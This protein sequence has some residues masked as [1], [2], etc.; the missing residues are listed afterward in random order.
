MLFHRV[1]GAITPLSISHVL[2]FRS[3][4]YPTKIMSTSIASRRRKP[5]RPTRTAVSAKRS[6]LPAYKNLALS[7]EK[8]VKDLL[9]RMTLEEKAA[10][11]MCVW[12][13]KPETLVDANG[14]FDLQK[15]KAAFR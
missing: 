7:A 4:H 8:R 1:Y 6:R 5:T 13:Q 15:A 12:Q 2:R 10:Q 3:I 9:A 11:M 14:A